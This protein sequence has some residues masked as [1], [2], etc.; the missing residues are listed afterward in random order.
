MVL[1]H[2]RIKISNGLYILLLFF[3]AV[4][5]GTRVTLSRIKIISI[6]LKLIL[7]VWSLAK[8]VVGDGQLVQSI[9]FLVSDE[10]S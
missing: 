9:E 3:S 1:E 4:R 5:L 10:I 7:M 2:S 6:N 8:P